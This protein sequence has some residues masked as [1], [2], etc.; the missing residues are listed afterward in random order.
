MAECLGGVEDIFIKRGCVF[1]P[2]DLPVMRQ[3]G[4]MPIALVRQNVP[5]FGLIKHIVRDPKSETLVRGRATH[6]Q[7]L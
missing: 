4:P 6:V 1:G 7:L 5:K 3:S 2:S